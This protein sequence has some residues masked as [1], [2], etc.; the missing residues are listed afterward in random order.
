[1]ENLKKVNAE[2]INGEILCGKLQPRSLVFVGNTANGVT[3]YNTTAKCRVATPLSVAKAVAKIVLSVEKARA[4]ANSTANA[5]ES[6]KKVSN[7]L[8][9][10]LRCH[11]VYLTNGKGE[12]IENAGLSVNGKTEINGKAQTLRGVFKFAKSQPVYK[13]FVTDGKEFGTDELENALRSWC[14]AALEQLDWLERV[15]TAILNA[16]NTTEKQEKAAEKAAK[17]LTDTNAVTEN[18]AVAS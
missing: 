7:P 5:I 16:A 1:M 11:T 3:I 18:V 2:M 4:A 15:D 9:A 17:T 10:L 8:T 13:L 14:G 12:I 6:G